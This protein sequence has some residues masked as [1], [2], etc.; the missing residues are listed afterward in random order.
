[1]QTKVTLVKQI[2][3]MFAHSSYAIVCLCIVLI[4]NA[5]ESTCTNYLRKVHPPSLM[6]GTRSVKNII[7]FTKSSSKTSFAK[8]N[9]TEKAIIFKKYSNNQILNFRQE[10]L[11]P[12]SGNVKNTVQKMNLRKKEDYFKGSKWEIIRV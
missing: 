9:M 3:K 1:M 2:L 11:M 6:T 7:S 10:P 4:I 8:I 5:Y 12:S